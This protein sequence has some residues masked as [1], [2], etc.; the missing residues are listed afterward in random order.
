MAKI[1][2]LRELTN[3]LT[4]EFEENLQD[5]KNSNLSS[6]QTDMSNISQRNS[7]LTRELVQDDINTQHVID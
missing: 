5:I 4:L 6:F 1:E 3:E 2:T 7:S